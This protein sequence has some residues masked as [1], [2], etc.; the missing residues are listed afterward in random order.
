[1]ES[2][3]SW[4]D[5]LGPAGIVVE[6]IIATAVG[7]V[8]LLAFILGRRAI[9]RRMFRIRDERVIAIRDQWDPIVDGTIP[10]AKWRKNKLDSEIVETL[11]LDRLEVAQGEEFARLMNC[12]RRSG[13]LD[14]RIHEARTLRGWRRRQALVSLGRMRAAE[15]IPALAEALDARSFDTRMAAVRGLGRLS[16]PEAAIPLLDRLISGQL[17]LPSIPV[18]NALLGCCRMRPQVLVPYVRRAHAEMRAL[19]A[20]AL[21]EVATGELGEDLLLLAFDQQAEVRASAAR[22]LAETRLD[23]TVSALA[24]LAEDE[25]WFVRLRAVVAMGQLRHPRTIPYLVEALCDRNRFV[26]LRAAMALAR[27]REHLEDVLQQVEQKKDRY[28]MQALHS[29]LERQGVVLALVQELNTPQ[30]KRAEQILLTLL[31]AGA[32]RLMLSA[33]QHHSDWRSRIKLARLM[34]RSGMKELTQ[35]LEQAVQREPSA[36][37][38]RILRWVLDRLRGGAMDRPDQVLSPAS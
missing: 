6:A 31:R 15:A 20:R 21:G 22:S 5:K 36:R 37:Q 32:Y 34:A 38:R 12:L 1:M 7:I 35:F 29:E 19:L 16:I 14:Q 33:L 3:F 11:L 8:L 28:A 26:R 23:V 10:P 4:I 25:E 24:M 18:Q 27:L 2:A 17:T 13:L 9:R 30:A